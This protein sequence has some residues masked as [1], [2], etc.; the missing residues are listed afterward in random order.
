MMPSGAEARP[1]ACRKILLPHSAANP[2]ATAVSATQRRKPI[3]TLAGD[4]ANLLPRLP[5]LAGGAIGKCRCFA[6]TGKTGN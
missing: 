2:A 6:M 4:S 1:S 3:S 5:Q